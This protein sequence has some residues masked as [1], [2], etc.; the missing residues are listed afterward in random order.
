MNENQFYLIFHDQL[1]GI[2]LNLEK[3]A[4]VTLKTGSYYLTVGIR[5]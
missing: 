3:T 5:T 2:F 1:I 4:E